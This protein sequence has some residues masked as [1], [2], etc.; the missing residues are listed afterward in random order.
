MSSASSTASGRS[1]V[2]GDGTAGLPGRARGRHTP[3][4]DLRFSC[5]GAFDAIGFPDIGLRARHPA[6]HHGAHPG[7]D[8][9][10]SEGLEMRSPPESRDRAQQE[11]AR[12]SW[13]LFVE[14]PAIPG[15]GLADP[16]ARASL[17]RLL[18]ILRVKRSERVEL[19]R[20]LPGVVRRGARV[21]LLP[22]ATAL[23]EAGIACVLRRRPEPPAGLEPARDPPTD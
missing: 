23:R 2:Q 5:S 4:L 16:D 8:R 17:Q 19:L 22:L 12:Q 21:D 20:R 13:E 14:R 7:L 10:R 15:A 3:A 1:D 18:R 11:R 6:C 9:R